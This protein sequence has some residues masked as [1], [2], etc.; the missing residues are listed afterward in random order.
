MFTGWVGGA[1]L[2]VLHTPLQA[3][4]NNIFFKRRYKGN[5]QIK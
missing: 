5:T 1:C 4:R 2:A 3:D